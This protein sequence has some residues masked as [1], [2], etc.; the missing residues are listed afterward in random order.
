M[1][2]EERAIAKLH[3]HG[4]EHISSFAAAKLEINAGIDAVGSLDMISVEE[5]D[6]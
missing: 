4:D 1:T 3:M 5:I 2:D 6:A